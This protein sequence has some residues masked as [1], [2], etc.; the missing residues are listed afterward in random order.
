MLSRRAES[1]NSN[2]DRDVTD[3]ALSRDRK[4]SNKNNKIRVRN[5]VSLFILHTRQISPLKADL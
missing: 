4:T 3:A 2:S 5:D 1:A